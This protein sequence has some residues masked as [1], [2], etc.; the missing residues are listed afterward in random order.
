[1][2]FTG[3]EITPKGIIQIKTA[4]PEKWKSITV[5][6]VGLQQKTYVNRQ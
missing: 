5:T 3:L 1:M 6:G 4:L 2:G